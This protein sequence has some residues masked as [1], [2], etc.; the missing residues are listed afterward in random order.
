MEA[1]PVLASKIKKERPRDVVVAK[2]VGVNDLQELDFYL[3]SGKYDGLSTFSRAEAEHWRTVGLKEIGKIN[4]DKVIKVPIISINTLIEEY[5]TK[6]PDFISLDIEGLDLD[7]LKTMN[8]EKF[9]P[10][11]LCI[12]TL[13]YDDKQVEHKNEELIAFVKEKGYVVYADTNIN[14]IFLKQSL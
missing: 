3:F 12:E 2:G 11:V 6:T 13:Q 9:K 1:N 10:A 5:C 14:T 7:I 4:Y 8:F